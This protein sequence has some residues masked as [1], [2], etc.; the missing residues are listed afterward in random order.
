MANNA[1][2]LLNS[3]EDD[4]V[5]QYSNKYDQYNPKQ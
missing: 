1:Y 5:I 2:E 3:K 4:L